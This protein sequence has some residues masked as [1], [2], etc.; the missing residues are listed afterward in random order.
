MSNRQFET[1]AE[2]L[3][4]WQNRLPQSAPDIGETLARTSLYRECACVCLPPGK[5]HKTTSCHSPKQLHP[6]P[7]DSVSH[8]VLTLQGGRLAA[9]HRVSR[10]RHQENPCAGTAR[11]AYPGLPL[12]HS[13]VEA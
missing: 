4:L 9:A 7:G 13:G 11:A 12:A 1:L 6:P 2:T 8:W 3:A 10:R 5:E